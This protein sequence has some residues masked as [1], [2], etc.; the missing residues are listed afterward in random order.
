KF[1]EIQ[2]LKFPEDILVD[3]IGAVHEIGSAQ[4]T[5]TTGKLNISF[6]IKDLGGIILDCILWESVASKFMEFCK[7]RTEEGPLILIIRRARLQKPTDR[8]PLQISNAWSGTKLII[9]ED[10]PDINH[11]KNSLLGDNS[12]ATQNKMMSYS[13]QKFATTTSG[14]QLTPEDHFIQDC[15]ILKLADIIQLQKDEIVVTVAKT[16]HLKCTDRGWYLL[17]CNSCIKE[18]K[19]SEPPYECA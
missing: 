11:F 18:A 5:A 1:E 9:N 7:N 2:S 8:Y 3:V 15:R 4:T 19:G 14:S 16:S 6:R 17:G 10:I 12:Y 13:S